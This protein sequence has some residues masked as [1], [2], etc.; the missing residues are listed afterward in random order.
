VAPVYD[1]LSTIA[2][3]LTDSA[4]QPMRADTHLGQRVGGQADIRKVT[5]DSLIDEA[6]GWGIRRRAAATVVTETVDRVLASIPA[7]PGDDRV[8]AVIRGQAERL[9]RG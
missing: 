3:E 2:L 5:A 7:T 9:R 4:G 8:L 6:V 1:V